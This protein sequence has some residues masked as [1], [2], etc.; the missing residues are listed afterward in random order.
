MRV[1]EKLIKYIS[2]YIKVSNN[3]GLVLKIRKYSP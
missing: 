3:E 2:I 1:Q